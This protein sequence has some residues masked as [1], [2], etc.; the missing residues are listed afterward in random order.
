MKVMSETLHS[1]LLKKQVAG[2][3]GVLILKD[4]NAISFQKIVKIKLSLDTNT[5]DSVTIQP[6]Q[7]QDKNVTGIVDVR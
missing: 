5:V 3:L 6:E 4:G 1:K 7:G 2:T